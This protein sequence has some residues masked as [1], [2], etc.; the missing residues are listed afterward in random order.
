[1]SNPCAPILLPLCQ[2]LPPLCP[3]TPLLCSSLQQGTD[4]VFYHVLVDARDWP[5]GGDHPPVAYVAE[6]LLTAG[7]S[8]DFASETPLVSREGGWGVSCAAAVQT[9]AA[10]AACWP[11]PMR[12]QWWMLVALSPTNRLHSPC[13]LPSP[14][15]GSFEHPYSYLLFLG[16]DG[17][18]NMV[19]PALWPACVAC[20]VPCLLA[21]LLAVPPP[22]L[23]AARL[24]LLQHGGQPKKPA[25]SCCP[26]SSSS[27]ATN[28]PNKPCCVQV[29]CRQ[30]R[31]KYCVERRDIYSA[32]GR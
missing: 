25:H 30:L 22:C 7:S 29:P 5:P 1:M 24:S 12:P 8:V 10:W 19:R 3:S 2:P 26:V 21:G 11:L 9:R 13:P 15:D 31:D 18:G 27:S 23:R 17:Q 32:G 14:Q 16:A 6:E 4:Q 28:H 20:L